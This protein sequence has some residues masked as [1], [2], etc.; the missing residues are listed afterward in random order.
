MEQLSRM[1]FIENQ[2]EDPVE[3]FSNLITAYKT[4]N[5]EIPFIPMNIATIDDE[6]G[7]LNRSV[8][9]RGLED[10]HIIFVTEKNTVKYAN[11]IKDPRTS[12]TFLFEKI[13]W[14][15]VNSIWQV[16]VTHS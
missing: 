16:I 7:V 14:N 9:Y 13:E 5:P 8:V 2:P 6:F 12:I 11:L 15:G 3:L 10:G 1:A 4:T